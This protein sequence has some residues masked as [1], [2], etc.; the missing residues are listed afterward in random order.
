[1]PTNNNTIKMVLELHKNGL[2]ILQIAK[3][4]NLTIAEVSNV[5]SVY[6]KN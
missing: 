4:L 2:S 6:S 5:I 3:H 1:M